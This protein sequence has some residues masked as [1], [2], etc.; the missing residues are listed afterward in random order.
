MK[1]FLEELQERCL[2]SGVKVVFT[3]C[4]KNAP[5]NG[6]TRW[7]NDTPLIQLSNRFNRNDI[8]WFTFFHEAAHILKHNKK[9]VFIEGM[10]YSCDGKEKESEADVWAADYLVSRKDER[11]ML[12]APLFVKED[13]EQFAERIGTHPAIVAGRLAKLG[14]IKHSVGHTFGFFRKIELNG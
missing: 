7:I 9:D 14:V 11:Q 8:F 12:E 3:P 1:V 6:S 10:D 4:L 13:F 5:L 2:I